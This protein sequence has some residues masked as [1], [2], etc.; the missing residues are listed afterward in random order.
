MNVGYSLNIEVGKV[1]GN[2]NY[3]LYLRVDGDTKDVIGVS[4][5]TSTYERGIIINFTEAGVHEVVVDLISKGGDALDINNAYM[6]T[7]DVTE[8]PRVLLVSGDSRSPLISVL[9]GNY[10]VTVESRYEGSG[11]Y[12]AVFLDNLNS[13]VLNRWV[14]NSLHA[15]VVDGNGLV[16]VGGDNAFENGAYRDSLVETLLPVMS[17][18]PPKEKRKPIAVLFLID[19]SSSMRDMSSTY[20][21][22]YLDEIKANVIGIIRE[23]DDEDS[24]GVKAFNVPVWDIVPMMEIGDNRELIE[25]NVMRLQPAKEGGTMFTPVF[26]AAKGTM[27]K[28]E[29]K[30][31]V[32]FM[33]DGLIP[34]TESKDIFLN[35]I[36]S[37]A[38]DG[39]KV[40]TASFGYEA[41][42]ISGADLMEDIAEKGNGKYYAIELRERL[43]ID[44]RR[45]EEED[46]EEKG[47]YKIGVF[48]PYHFITRNIPDFSASIDRYNA[49]TGRSI[50]QV[51]ISTEDKMPI[52]T[53]WRFGLGRVTAVTTDNG[54]DWAS[55]LYSSGRGVLVSAV[56]NWA[57]GDLE[58]GKDVRINTEDVFLGERARVS[59]VSEREPLLFMVDGGEVE[60]LR[61]KQTDINEHSTFVGAD[62]VGFYFLKAETSDDVDT[63]AIAVNY[64]REY[65]ELGVDTE[66][67][68]AIAELT[69]GGVYNES[70]VE[71]LKED[72]VEFA[73]R[74]S[75]KETV[76]KIPLQLYLMAA[77]LLLFFVDTVVRRVRDVRRRRSMSKYMGAG[78]QGVEGK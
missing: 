23:L 26:L 69:G 25:N 39:V 62:D 32:I 2:V 74:G 4:Q 45:E 30:R 50:A 22:S 37:M 59:V 17:T 61:L 5:N 15:Y 47:Y 54:G 51:L 46:E 64:P 19:V 18:D 76:N 13:S 9:G 29:S 77:A 6:K 24:V 35:E 3:T 72:V 20:P 42:M 12:D 43:K 7:V 73:R 36:K 60:E 78:L 58:K 53:V 27:Q 10:D 67:L 1:G 28:C 71:E 31:H 21:G 11:D 66:T 63:D 48:D 16:V 55:N 52:V 8:K 56:T 57:V 49:V 70:E 14:V 40:N 34:S 33:S 75:L 68:R 41:N 38:K 44:F 65:S